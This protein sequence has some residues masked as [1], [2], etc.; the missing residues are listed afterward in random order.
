MPTPA[1]QP[2]PH[3]TPSTHD[4][5]GMRSVVTVGVFDGVHKGHRALIAACRQIARA[6]KSAGAARPGSQTSEPRVITIVLDPHPASVLAPN[7]EPARLTTFA[8]R[9][10]LLKEAGADAVVRLEPTA[11]LLN[12]SPAGFVDKVVQEY[13]P[14]AWVEG[15]DFRF[16]KGRAG[17]VQTLRQFGKALE[18]ASTADEGFT[19]HVVGEKEPIEAVLTDHSIVPCRSTV[20]RWLVSHGRVRDAAEI[21]GTFYTLDGTV[22]RGDRRGRTIGYPTANIACENL[23]PADG[24]YAGTATLGDGRRFAA[25]ISIGTKPTFASGED[26]PRA[27]E[28]YLL[29]AP[30]HDG[31]PNLAGLPEYG[32]R[33]ELTLISYLRDQVK[34][35]SLDDLL[36]QLARDCERTRQIY[37]E[38]TGTGTLAPARVS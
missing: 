25:A 20:A 35:A 23:V 8:R 10:R 27:V 34:F 3:A 16:G 29:D 6:T 12:L 9:E 19:V 37:Q 38:S 33:I 18:A 13:R 14:I 2:P 36:D 28:A 7:Q 32:W 30:L 24:V 21:L 31:G 15:P 26:P 5:A 11:E 4:G 22:E 1:T 17:D